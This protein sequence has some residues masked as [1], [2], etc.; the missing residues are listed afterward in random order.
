M[1]ITDALCR[2]WLDLAWHFDPAAGS[3]A[4]V[5]A[6]DFRLGRFDRESVREHVAAGR[7]IAGALEELEVEEVADE[8]DRT[9]LLGEIRSTLARLELDQPHQRDPVFWLD[10]LARAL[11]AP[12]RDPDAVE[13]GRAALARLREVPDFLAA[14]RDTI[15]RPAGPASETAMAMVPGLVALAHELVERF[16]T[17][18]P[19]EAAELAAAA[20]EAEAALARTRLALGDEL[21]P[22]PDVHAGAVGED[23]F[24]WILHHQFMLR[25]S[26]GEVWRWGRALA[27]GIAPELARTAA[28]IDPGRDW[29]EVFEAVRDAALITGDLRVAALDALAH[30]RDLARAAGW[31]LER[32]G[33]IAVEEAPAVLA[34]L[35]PFARYA[36]PAGGL[37]GQLLLAAPTAAAD[38]GTAA[39]WRGEL[40]RHRLAVLAAHDGWPGRHAQAL[41]AREAASVVRREVV[42]PIATAGWGCY[43]EDLVG[44]GGGF[45]SVEERL[46]HQV[47]S[48][49]RALRVVVDAGIHT[50]QLTV[51]AAMDLLVRE[52]PIDPHAARAEVRRVVAEPGAAAAYALGRREYHLLREAWSGQAGPSASEREFHEAVLAHGRI[53]PSLVAWGLGLGA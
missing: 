47:L 28:A 34:T 22:D 25:Q 43:A 13:A 44:V 38:H 17:D 6:A 45:V 33:E 26:P 9:A 20:T 41:A 37:E 2:S 8:I 35:A 46:A 1:P 29:R 32:D 51:T 18:D 15:R 21:A 24:G 48:L 36:P 42:V 52:L 31:L 39:W 14:A 49:L 3:A 50:R 16:R 10:H 12:L 4:G 19:G 40:D 27:D 23:R 11:A 5:A 30:A 53:P 7:A